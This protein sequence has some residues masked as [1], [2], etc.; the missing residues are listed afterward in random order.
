MTMTLGEAFPDAE[1][2][3]KA[4]A[5]IKHNA[6]L[7]V[8]IAQLII[9]DAEIQLKCKDHVA[10]GVGIAAVV[11]AV[12]KCVEGYQL[13]PQI[14][15]FAGLA[16]YFDGLKVD[17]AKRFEEAKNTPAAQPT[18]LNDQVGVGDNIE[19]KLN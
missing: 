9:S 1:Q 11:D 10:V 3:A 5:L 15:H 14:E 19:L 6:I 7:I 17:A 8:R 13:E 18:G 16:T 4:D 2:A 12:R